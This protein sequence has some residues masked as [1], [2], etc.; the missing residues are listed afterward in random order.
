M[1]PRSQNQSVGC[2]YRHRG[3]PAVIQAIHLQL[4]LPTQVS[5]PGA[6]NLLGFCR[7]LLLGGRGFPLLLLS[8]FPKL[9]QVLDPT[10]IDDFPP[11]V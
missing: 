9:D 4:P 1:S 10:H 2:E 8:F 6:Y 5:S 3:H 7:R 11:Q